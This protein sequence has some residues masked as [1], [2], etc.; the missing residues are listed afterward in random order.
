MA[1]VDAFCRRQYPR[2]VGMLGLYCGDVPLAEDLAQEA[3]VRVVREWPRL[4]SDADAQRWITRVAFNL[5]KSSLRMR[6][7]RQRVLARHA[8]HLAPGAGSGE[9]ATALAVRAAVARLPERERR[10]IILRFFSDMSV[11]EAAELMGCPE[12]T[13]KSLTHA[14]I[15]RL[16]DAGLEVDDA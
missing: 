8:S 5:A 6:A 7:T 10:V 11:S 4:P 9:L 2:L 16:R 12:G 3:L 15:R 1:D 13:V 14:A